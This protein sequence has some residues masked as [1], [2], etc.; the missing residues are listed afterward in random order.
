[1]PAWAAAVVMAW[2]GL[3]LA[4]YLADRARGGR[5]V[6]CLFKR[7]TGEPCPACGGTRAVAALVSGDARGAVAMNPLVAVGS[8]LFA[9]WLA[10]R[11][12]LG[13]GVVLER[14]ERRAAWV[15]GLLALGAN[16]AWLIARSR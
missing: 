7:V 11:L 1:V 8:V 4:A 13:R 6:L 16:W 10:G 5:T 3:V 2:G 14:G 9:A 12:L 15:L